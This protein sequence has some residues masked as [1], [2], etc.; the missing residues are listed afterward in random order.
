VRLPPDLGRDTEVPETRYA[1]TPGGLNIA[2]QV[3]GE[4]PLDLLAL[5][6]SGGNVELGWE[7]PAYAHVL[8]RLASFSRLIFFDPAGSGL[9]DP[10]GVSEQPSFE[11]RAEEMLAVLDDVGS[12]QAAVVANGVGGLLAIFFAASYPRRTSALVLDGCYARK[13]WAPDYSWGT[14]PELLEKAVARLRTGT[15]V[16][17]EPY[18]RAVAPN[19]LSDPEFVSQWGRFMRSVHSPARARAT[20]EVGAFADL[21]SV[22]PT[23]QASTLVLYRSGDGFAGPPHAQY[24]AQNIRD[25]K[26]VELSGEDNLLCVGDSDADLDEIEEFLTGVRRAPDTDRVLATV[27]FTDIVGSTNLAAA[28]GDQ[29]WKDLLDRHD[30]VV[31]RQLERFGGREVNT[32][33]DG[34]LATFDGPGRAVRCACAIR[35]AVSA[36]DIEVRAGVHTGE[37]ELRGAD[38]AGMAVHIGARVAALATAGEVLVSGTVPPLVAGSGLVFEDRGEHELKGVPGSWRLFAVEG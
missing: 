10:L 11:E 14:P 3:L 24:L 7:V 27:L 13:A 33:G 21:R 25:A 38:V 34:F 6:I 12:E 20:G 17:E 23:I 19:A 4:G 2:Y 26:L 9:S 1:T 16:G 36:L 15:N 32:V 18:W 35:D 30:R 29:R 28:M 5:L 37:I 22:L 8:Q 31:R